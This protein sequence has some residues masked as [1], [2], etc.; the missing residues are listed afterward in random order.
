[1][2][3]R[4]HWSF[5]QAGDTWRKA[6][7]YDGLSG[8]P[9]LEAHVEFARCAE[10]NGIESLLLAFSF[11]RPDPIVL[12]TAVGLETERITL[13][14]ACRP[15]VI[16]PVAFVQQVN[17]VAALTGGRVS[18]NVVAG[19][20]PHE[21]AYYGDF[22]GHDERYERA[23]EFLDVCRA[24]WQGV[25]EVSYEGRHYRVERGRLETPFVSPNA[26]AP[27]IYLGGNS[28]QA[29]ELAARHAS[30]LLRYPDAPERL[31]PGAERLIRAGAR[32]GIRIALVGRPSRDEA[33]AAALAVQARARELSQG[34]RRQ[35]VDR[36]DSVA[37]RSTLDLADAAE[38]EWLKPWLWTGAVPFVGEVCL[39]GTAEEIAAGLLEYGAA[40]VTDFLFSGWPDEAEM[41]FFGREVLPRIRQAEEAAGQAA[42]AFRTAR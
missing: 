41:D 3:L 23:G 1:M 4:F 34:Q 21:H 14:V 22:L 20:S 37:F 9:D 35:F 18:I 15:G 5:T 33:V 6:R 17:T 25:G 19:H 39:V 30:C 2:A 7:T 10:R 13:M 29:E 16:S 40:G 28:A 27:E 11:N 24:F 36:T 32:A 42:M 38:G 26:A 8:V 31:R 12:A